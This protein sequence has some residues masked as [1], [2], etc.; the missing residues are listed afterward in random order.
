MRELEISNELSCIHIYSS[1]HSIQYAIL[2]SESSEARKLSSIDGSSLVLS[3]RTASANENFLLF[4]SDAD[5]RQVSRKDSR[6]CK[7][8]LV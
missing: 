2:S 5:A 6:G 7:W 1:I 3:L 4:L 8:S